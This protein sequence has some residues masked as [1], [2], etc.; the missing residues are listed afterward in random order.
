MSLCTLSMNIRSIKLALF[1]V[2]DD[3]TEDTLEEIMTDVLTS[4]VDGM[5]VFVN[6]DLKK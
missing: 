1:R 5:L 4:K 6:A 3:Y 2:P